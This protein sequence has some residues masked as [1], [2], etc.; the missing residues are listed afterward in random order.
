MH[1]NQNVFNKLKEFWKIL[2]VFNRIKIHLYQQ[3]K[4]TLS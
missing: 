1:L 3:K 4:N 2:F